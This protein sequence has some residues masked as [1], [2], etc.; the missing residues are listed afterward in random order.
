MQA[1]GFEKSVSRRPAKTRLS[2]TLHFSFKINKQCCALCPLRKP[3]CNF[4]NN[5]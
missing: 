1:K 3:R 5:G 4:E 2:K